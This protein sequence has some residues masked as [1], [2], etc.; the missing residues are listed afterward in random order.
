MAKSRPITDGLIA[1]LERRYLENC[2]AEDK[3]AYSRLA[4]GEKIRVARDS[5]TAEASKANPKIKAYLEKR[6]KRGRAKPPG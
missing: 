4:P 6:S 2:S 3:D 5:F 1:A